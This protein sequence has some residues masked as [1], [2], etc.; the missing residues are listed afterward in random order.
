M[1]SNPSPKPGFD[2]GLTLVLLS[3]RSTEVLGFGARVTEPSSRDGAEELGNA[4]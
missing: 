2:T 1:K 4:E 3:S